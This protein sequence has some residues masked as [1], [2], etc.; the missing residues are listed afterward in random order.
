MAPAKS[1]PGAASEYRALSAK[2]G[3]ERTE[4]AI[5]APGTAAA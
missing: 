5:D 4:I 3:L 1:G 2:T